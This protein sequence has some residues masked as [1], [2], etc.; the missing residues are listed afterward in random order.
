MATISKSLSSSLTAPNE[1][2]KSVPFT[3][4][5]ELHHTAQGLT[6]DYDSSKFVCP[7]LKNVTHKA[8]QLNKIPVRITPRTRQNSYTKSLRHCNNLRPIQVNKIAPSQPRLIPCC[9]VL[10]ARSI[11]EP[12]AFPALGADIKS[13]NIDVCCI[14]ETWLKPTIPSSLLCPPNFSI[15]RKDR[16]NCRG[17]GVAILCRNDWRMQPLPDLD[18]PFEC[19]R[20]KIIAQNSEFFVA[21]IYHPPDYEYNEQDLI[22]FLIDSCEQLL[23]S[24]SNSNIIIAGDINNLNIRSVLNQLP[25]TQLVKTP[26]RGLKILDVFITNVPNYWKSVKV[27]K[28]LVRSDHDMVITYPRNTV[29]AIRTNSYFRDVRQ[30]IIN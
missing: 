25:F 18:N 16:T 8:T 27:V 9:S 10:N 17:A 13:N 19:L 26:T 28:S 11:A 22:E 7:F 29:K 30:Q 2:P 4:N 3:P 6:G 15:I 20:T 5:D 1:L 14:T 21:T 24:K 12:D 23:L